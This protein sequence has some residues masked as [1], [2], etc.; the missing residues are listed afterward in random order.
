M[1]STDSRLWKSENADFC[2]VC[3]GTGVQTTNCPRCGGAGVR[4]ANNGAPTTK[5]KRCGLPMPVE[6]A[7]PELVL[8]THVTLEWCILALRTE[9]HRL[10]EVERK[11]LEQSEYIQAHGLTEW[12]MSLKDAEIERLRATLAA[13]EFSDEGYCLWCYHRGAE[14]HALDCQ[15]QVA[16]GLS[17]QSAESH[18]AEQP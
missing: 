2:P 3:N 16:L 17:E 10:R 7:G 8:G 1:T 12:E 18:E 11:A 14:P 5:C 15:R 4:T 6:I 9:V 13:V